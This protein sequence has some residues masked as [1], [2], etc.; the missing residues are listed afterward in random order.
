MM[1]WK[2]YLAEQ[3]LS[4]RVTTQVTGQELLVTH[5]LSSILRVISTAHPHAGMVTSNT[6]V[7]HKIVK[8][9]SSL[10]P[11]CH[12]YDKVSIFQTVRNHNI[13][14]LVWKTPVNYYNKKHIC[15]YIIICSIKWLCLSVYYMS[16]TWLQLCI[17]VYFYIY[18][19]HTS[20]EM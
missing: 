6:G 7:F 14:K 8:N 5:S 17:S 2:L 3:T 16:C 4:L 18:N 1:L 9:S 11:I 19:L 13:H 12:C 20:Q 15:I 10:S